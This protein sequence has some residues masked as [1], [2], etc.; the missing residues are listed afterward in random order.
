MQRN[1]LKPKCEHFLKEIKHNGITLIK[2]SYKYYNCL[3]AACLLST[4]I[5]VIEPTIYI[6]MELYGVTE[7]LD[8]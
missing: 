1:G 8:F 2:S 6:Y 7:T 3:F 5:N 4:E